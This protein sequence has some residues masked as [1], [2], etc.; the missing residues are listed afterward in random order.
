M[1]WKGCCLICGMAVVDDGL[2]KVMTQAG[3]CVGNGSSEFGLKCLR[4]AVDV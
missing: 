1:V 3:Y 2:C 4:E